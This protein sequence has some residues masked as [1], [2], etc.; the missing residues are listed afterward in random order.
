MHTNEQLIHLCQ[1]LIKRPSLSGSEGEV[2][3]YIQGTM[4]QLG[5]DE[6]FVDAF[7]SVT[8]SIYGNKEGPCILMDGHIDTVGV[9][10]PALWRH[11][12][13]QG[14]VDGGLLYG[15]GT[16]DMKGALSAMLIA[17][18]DFKQKTNGNFGGSVH[19]SC[20]VC[21][22]CFEGFS[23]RLITKRIKPDVVIVGEASSLTIKRGQRG[24]AEIVL[25]TFGKSC[26][27]SNP[28]QGV[29][30]VHSMLTLLAEVLALEP[31]HHPILGEG[32]MV[33]TDIISAPYPGLSVVPESCKV[34][35]DRRLL[36]GETESSILLPIQQILDK[37]PD[38]KA[39]VSIAEGTLTCYTGVPINA[40]RFF[41]AWLLPDDHPLV[42]TAKQAL[43]TSP[44]SHYSFCTNASHFCAEAGIP[45]IGYG[46]SEESLA[47]TVDEYSTVEQLSQAWRGYLSLLDHLLL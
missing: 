39:S 8:G 17:A 32:I 37:H 15:R 44:L 22:E 40:K 33:L 7:G 46:P 34:T 43:P 36:P 28:Q 1:D 45:T 3:S 30:A 26:H 29:N 11:D 47:H 25:Q 13:Y 21:E 14:T 2:A 9:E 6:I 24:R 5:F 16:S 4:Q 12:P 42:Q 23:A 35:F 41:P 31:P 10:N 19:V 27:S 20:T 18:A 38:L